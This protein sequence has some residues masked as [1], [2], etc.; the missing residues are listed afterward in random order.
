MSKRDDGSIESRLARVEAKIDRI[1]FVVLAVLVLVTALFV[2][3]FGLMPVIVVALT[4]G[5]AACI[6]Y[7]SVYFVNRL[8]R[9]RIETHEG[10]EE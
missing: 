8:L 6:I 4:I 7:A 5:V 9:R 10:W 2:G 3:A 1:M